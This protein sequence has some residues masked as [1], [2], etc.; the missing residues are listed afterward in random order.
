MNKTCVQFMLNELLFVFLQL[1][2]VANMNKIIIVTGASSGF[3]K[4]IAERLAEH[5]HT[6]YGICRREMEHNKIN[7]RQGDIRDVERIAQITK[8][9]FEKEGRIDVLINNAGMGLG[10]ALELTSWEEI[11]LQME[12]NFYGCVNVCQKVLPYMRQQRRGRIIN[13]SSIAGIEGIPYQG[14]YSCSKFAIEGFSETLAAEMKRF[15]IAVSLVEPGDFA[16]GFTAVRVNSEATL[17]DPDYGPVFAR[18]R[19]RFEKEEIGG[20]KP[21][22]MAKKVEQ[23]VNARRPRLRYCVAN[24]EQKLSVLLK[25]VIPGNWNVAILR[26]Y[27]GS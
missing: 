17:K 23:I 10:G 6:V 5:G 15:G 19:E 24:F 2:R 25:R 3:G 27:Y 7:Y 20:L 13:F 26:S 14:F 18:V 1:K 4:S 22:Y 11:K 9:I 21:D 12:T 8:E 16:T